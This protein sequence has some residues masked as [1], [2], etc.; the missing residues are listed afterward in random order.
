MPVD[1]AA[2]R[3]AYPRLAEARREFETLRAL[4]P[5]AAADLPDHRALVEALCARAAAP[6]PALAS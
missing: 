1:L 4:G 2:L 5:H 6:E 3:Q